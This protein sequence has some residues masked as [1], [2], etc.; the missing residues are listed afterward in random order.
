[1]FAY[2]SSFD[3]PLSRW[4]VSRVANMKDM[5]Y[6]CERFNQSLS[7]WEVA[8]VTNMEGMFFGCRSFNQSLKEW[9]VSN[10]TNMNL[11]FEKCAAFNQ[12]IASWRWDLSKCSV[13]G[14]GNTGLS[15]E[16]Y[17]KALK[18]WYAESQRLKDRF[19]VQA[20]NLKFNQQGKTARDALIQ[21]LKWTF[22]GDI[23]SDLLSPRRIS[24]EREAVTLYKGERVVLR[25]STSGR[26][27]L[28]RVTQDNKV[29]KIIILNDNSVEVQG[30]HE[31]ETKLRVYLEQTTEQGEV[32]ADCQVKVLKS[33]R[34]F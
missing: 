30:L 23:Y 34:T 3:Q 31:G 28:I 18:Y 5:F 25:F 12:D 10:V 22:V 15:Q 7:R 13:I 16:H 33:G 6:G 32:F 14:L 17:S 19:T 21:E 26:E 11:M 1:M 8:N 29:L 20:T 9:D 27:N 2:C 24:F 4:D